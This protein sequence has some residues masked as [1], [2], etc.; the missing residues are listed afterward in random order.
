MTLNLVDIKERIATGEKLT[1][2]QREFLLEALNAYAP[3]PELMP[4]DVNEI[5][6]IVDQIRALLRGKAPQIVSA[7]LADMLSHFIVSHHPSMREEILQGHFELVRDLIPETERQKFGGKGH[8]GT[9]EDP[10]AK[11]SRH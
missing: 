1:N 7:I 8:P 11:K 2:V 10:D 9:R 5:E 4:C 3:D 6:G